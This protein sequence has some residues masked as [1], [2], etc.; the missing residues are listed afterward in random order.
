MIALAAIL[1]R[2]GPRDRRVAVRRPRRPAGRGHQRRRHGRPGSSAT[3]TQQHVTLS[4]RAV[5]GRRSWRSGSAPP[6][7]GRSTPARSSGA[8]PALHEEGA[9]PLGRSGRGNVVVKV[10]GHPIDAAAAPG[11][12]VLG[13]GRRRVSRAHARRSSSRAASS[14]AASATTGTARSTPARRSRSASSPSGSRSSGTTRTT[15]RPRF[16]PA[17]EADVCLVSGGLGP[18]HDD[19]TVELVARV[20]GAP[21]RVDSEL[22]AQIEAVSR[23]VAERLAPA[24][25]RVRAGRHEAGD[26]FPTAPT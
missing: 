6:P 9:V 21:L 11:A 26:R 25:R 15:S 19:R 4:V 17:S 13:R 2:D 7:A 12:R 8:D 24:L 1:A 10:N 5:A 18:T 16:E 22:E 3:S 23:A 20:A 14:C